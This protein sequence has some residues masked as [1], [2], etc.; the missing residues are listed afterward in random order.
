MPDWFWT[1][2]LYVFAAH[3][4]V[5]TGLAVKRKRLASALAAGAFL[6]LFLAIGLRLWQ[7]ESSLFGIRTYWYLRI[8]AWILAVAG[9]SLSWRQRRR[10]SSTTATD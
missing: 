10:K 5:F 6:L 3:F 4:L 9:I 7:P 2:M 1:C 8:P